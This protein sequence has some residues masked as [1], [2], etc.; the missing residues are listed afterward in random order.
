M[1]IKGEDIPYLARIAAVADSFD[2]MTSKRTYKTQNRSNVRLNKLNSSKSLWTST[3]KRNFSKFET[4][5]YV[6]PV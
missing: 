3:Y 5:I 6:Q 1:A 2:A 4:I